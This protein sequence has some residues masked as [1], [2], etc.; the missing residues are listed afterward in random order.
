MN[1]ARYVT[2]R[3]GLSADESFQL[4]SYYNYFNNWKVCLRENTKEMQK[5]KAICVQNPGNLSDFTLA[6]ITSITYSAKSRHVVG[7]A[8][9]F[10]AVLALIV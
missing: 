4:I 1:S 3:V 7:V 6:D 9:T 8:V 2:F 10:N 5:I